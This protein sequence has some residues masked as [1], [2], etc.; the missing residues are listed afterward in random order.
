MLLR[1]TFTVSEWLKL[2][3][4]LLDCSEK[5]L[6][7]EAEEIQEIFLSLRISG[8]GNNFVPVLASFKSVGYI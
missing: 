1:I 3:K 7:I 2:L 8:Y 4:Q 6:L 5:C